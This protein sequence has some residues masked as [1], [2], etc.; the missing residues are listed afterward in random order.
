MNRLRHRSDFLR[1][2]STSVRV[3]SRHFVFL[4]APSAVAPSTRVGITA[5]RKVGTAV[6]RNRARRLVRE[7]LRAMP[8][9]VPE[10]VDAVV[11]VRCALTDMRLQHVIGEWRSV[12]RLVMRRGAAVAATQ[13]AALGGTR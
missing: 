13:T 11:V 7:A 3:S 1:V 6:V 9:Y 5:S 4:L 10:G 2:H 8:T 12:Q